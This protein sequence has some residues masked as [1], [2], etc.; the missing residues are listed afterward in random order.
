MTRLVTMFIAFLLLIPLLPWLPLGMNVKGKLV[1]VV[2]AFVIAGLSFAIESYIP[3]WQNILLSLILAG[4]FA[5]L[6]FKYAAGR[7]KEGQEGEAEEEE[8]PLQH[9][10]ES[11]DDLYSV[12]DL[13]TSVNTSLD[14]LEPEQNVSE[15]YKEEAQEMNVEPI[16]LDEENE[17]SVLDLEVLEHEKQELE[18]EEEYNHLSSDEESEEAELSDDLIDDLAFFED[19]RELPIQEDVKETELPTDNEEDMYLAS[20]FDELLEEDEDKEQVN[21]EDVSHD[22]NEQ[23]E[24]PALIEENDFL[25]SMELEDPQQDEE[26]V[27][28]ELEPP[29]DDVEYLELLTIEEQDEIVESDSTEVYEEPL[30]DDVIVPFVSIE[31]DDQDEAMDETQPVQETEGELVPLTLDDLDATDEDSLESN[32]QE[33]A[34]LEIAA[35][36]HLESEQEIVSQLEESHLFDD[37]ENTDEEDTSTEDLAGHTDTILEIDESESLSSV[38]DSELDSELFEDEADKEE[39]LPLTEQTEEGPD[40]KATEEEQESTLNEEEIEE[41]N[42]ET[43]PL[44]H[45]W[46]SILM[47]ELEWKKESLPFKEAEQSMRGYLNA[48]LH[49][50]DHYMFAKLLLTFYLEQAK[51][52]EALG[53]VEEIEGRFE[54]Y[55]LI[56]SELQLTK[57]FIE[58]KIQ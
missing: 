30:E 44:A 49:D 4:S 14:D 47:K 36:E 24:A 32:P 6:F 37:P 23:A 56:Q 19:D 31:T 3:L 21:H 12:E 39:H 29:E 16:V 13:S 42:E 50:R 18:E 22:Q 53:W 51:Y 5:Y 1:L 25:S 54:R 8:I 46:L 10:D 17:I 43:K 57:S 45:E 27:E 38:I 2:L 7:F 28:A 20:L 9:Q 34:E 33:E 26:L 15:S 35:A 40:I 52:K 41:V 48:S 11:E 58:D 55:P